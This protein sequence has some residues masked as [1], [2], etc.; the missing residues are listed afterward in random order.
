M[1]IGS[2]NLRLTAPVNIACNYILSEH[3]Y[4]CF[5][6]MRQGHLITNAI[7]L[8]LRVTTSSVNSNKKNMSFLLLYEE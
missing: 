8:V 7:S 3:I 2:R 4:I 5:R 1:L 6:M